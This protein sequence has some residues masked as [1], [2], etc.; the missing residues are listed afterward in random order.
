MLEERRQ[1]R[2]TEF[3]GKLRQKAKVSISDRAL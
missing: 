3:L 2:V 1:E